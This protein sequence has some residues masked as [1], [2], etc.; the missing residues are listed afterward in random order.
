MSEN[1]MD[2]GLPASLRP[3]AG[4][5]LDVDSHEMMPAQL[6]VQTFGNAAKPWADFMIAQK[7]AGTESDLNMPDFAGDTT[8]IHL[9]SVQSTKGP[10][11]PGSTDMTR[12]V[13]VLDQMSVK[14]QLMFPTGVGMGAMLLNAAPKGSPFYKIFGDRTRSISRD[15]LEANNSWMTECLRSFP[16]IRPVAPIFAESPKKLISATKSL[17]DKGIRGIWIAAGHP[18]AGVSPASNELD[19]FYAMLAEANVPLTVHLSN[20]T[21]IFQTTEWR[22][23]KAFDNY[24]ATDEVSLDPWNLSTMHLPAQNFIATMVTGG[25]F[26]RHPTLRMGAL[27]YC[28]HWIA[29]LARMLDLWHEN[30]QSIQPAMFA[31]GST[32][33][34]LPMRPSEYIARNVRV[35]P[36]DFEPVG[37]YI[38]ENPGLVDVYVFQTD[39]P[40]VEG[41]KQTINKFAASLE[42]LGSTVMEKFFVK[43]G[44]LL[45]PA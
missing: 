16:R 20:E 5:L 33:R 7:P 43:N 34:R 9:K 3:F 4:K 27:E 41:G 32:G 37:Q 45:L 42:P 18:P 8:E 6:W 44:E 26:D 28:A 24:K 22:N 38:R 31:D 21:D 35:A 10:K 14:R 23:A 2:A 30:N 12:R 29:P 11:A 1:I 36:Y 19:G 40:H 25:V 17:I 13:K 39:Y 15:L